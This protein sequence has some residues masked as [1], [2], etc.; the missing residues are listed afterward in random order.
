[1]ACEQCATTARDLRELR[2]FLEEQF[3]ALNRKVDHMS[4]QQAEIEQDVQEIATD[5]G[6]MATQAG[7]VVTNLGDI[8]TEITALQQQIAAGGTV[9]LTSLTNLVTTA[10]TTA[11]AVAA[12]AAQAAGMDPNT[13]APAPSGN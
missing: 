2:L 10:S 7:Q 3:A 13:P 4:D 1:V 11:Q 8:A 5:L 6:T 9:D 12:V